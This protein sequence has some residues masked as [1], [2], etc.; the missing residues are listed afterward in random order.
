MSRGFQPLRTPTL[1]TGPA[2]AL[3]SHCQRHGRAAVCFAVAEKDQG[4]RG[5]SMKSFACTR[6]ALEL[7]TGE[8][9]VKCAVDEVGSA[10]QALGGMGSLYI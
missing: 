9:M 8:V 10:E 5:N 6:G 7:L 2:A 3:I 4:D 1:L